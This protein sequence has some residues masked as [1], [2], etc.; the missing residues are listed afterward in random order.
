MRCTFS[1]TGFG[2][3]MAASLCLSKIKSEHI[4]G[5]IR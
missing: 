1:G 3:G 5:A 4:R 2:D